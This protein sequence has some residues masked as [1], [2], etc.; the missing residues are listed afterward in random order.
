MQTADETPRSTDAQ[1]A[2]QEFKATK[3]FPNLDGLRAISIILVIIGHTI[4]PISF[5]GLHLNFG[6]VGVAL[7]FA[8]SGFLITTLLL[9]E[10]D[11]NGEIDL[12]K[13]YIRRSLRIFP[14]YY[15]VLGLYV[16]YVLTLAKNTPQAGTFWSN[17]PFFLTYTYNWFGDTG[18]TAIFYIAWSLC[19]EEQFYAVWPVVLKFNPKNAIRVAILVYVASLILTLPFFVTQFE[20]AVWYSIAGSVSSAIVGGVL[21]AFGL[22]HESTYRMI[23]QVSTDAGAFVML[24]LITGCG[25]IANHWGYWIAGLLGPIAVATCVATTPK[26]ISKALQI[27]LFK[28]TGK[29]SYGLY[30][31]HLL[32]KNIA[33]PVLKKLHIMN[34]YTLFIATYA[35]ALVI[36]LISFK[37]FEEKVLAY[38]ERFAA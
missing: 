4:Q 37:L 8:I 20:G 12:R 14:L 31:Y 9:R 28:L 16:V 33:L 7:F 26:A 11:K 15:W 19:T 22:H 25:A 38:K 1:S 30:L 13:F 3:F 2:F 36:S 27:Q 35:L 29:V 32:A 17:F 18:E 21:L 34:G 10:R 5:P 23:H 6:K 24:A